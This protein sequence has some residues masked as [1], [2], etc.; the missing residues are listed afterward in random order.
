M[1]APDW[2]TMLRPGSAVR[3]GVEADDGRA[4][5]VWRLWTVTTA[6]DVYIAGRAT[7]SWIK[8]SLHASG[9]WQHGFTSEAQNTG[10]AS[11]SGSRYFE[12]WQRP[13]EVASGVT[14]ALRIVI[15]TSQLRPGP[16][17]R[18][19]GR[20]VR[21]LPPPPRA[22]GVVFDVFLLAEGHQVVQLER[23]NR[24]GRIALPSGGTVE[25]VARTISFDADLSEDFADHVLKA[26][27]AAAS[28]G[29]PVPEGM[30]G[31]IAV[32]G[33]DPDFHTVKFLELAVDELPQAKPGV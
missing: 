16:S 19:R 8:A 24:V 7:G 14:L 33:W 17:T 6:D 32:H 15:P 1:T 13:P 21:R 10:W 26:R 5:T 27:T 30:V 18:G 31:R 28:Q 11:E 3:F 4:S 29:I 12:L 22:D 23:S 20:E 9:R 2:H 25:V